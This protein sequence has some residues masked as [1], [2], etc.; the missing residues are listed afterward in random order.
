M[1]PE[2]DRNCLRV[3]SKETELAPSLRA[4]TH[5]SFLSV[6]PLKIEGRRGQ[7]N[8]TKENAFVVCCF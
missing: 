4:A 2:L 5:S 7:C 8:L 1:G 3:Y 6:S